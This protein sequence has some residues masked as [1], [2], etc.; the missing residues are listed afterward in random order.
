MPQGFGASLILGGSMEPEISTDDLVFVKK[1]TERKVGDVV[2]YNTGE[3][4]VLQRITK[5]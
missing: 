5:I 4:N 3:S 1:P 2:L